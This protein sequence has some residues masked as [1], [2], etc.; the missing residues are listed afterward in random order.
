[1]KKIVLLTIAL[2]V[3]SIVSYAQGTVRGKI[4]DKN[5]ET[6]IGVVVKLA[7]NPAGGRTTDFDGNFSIKL[8]DSTLQTLIITYLGFDT[9][10]ETVKA[11]NNEVIVKDFT[12]KE[13]SHEQKVVEIVAKASKAKEYYMENVKKNSSTTIDFISAETMK[14]TGDANV[15]AAI[16]RVP[17]VSTSVDG[18]ITVRGIGDRY[19]KTTIN[20][21]RIPTLDPFTNNIKL[22]MIPANLVDNV[23]IEKTA[24]PHLPG[25]WAGAYI[26]VVT[27]DYPDKL[28]LNVES[29][30]GY[31]TQSTFKDVLSSHRSSTDWLGYDSDRDHS[32]DKNNAVS[33]ANVH[34]TQYQEYVAL[35]LG[36][37]FK[38][39]GV[40][41]KT[42]WTENY[43][44]LGLVQL[45]LLPKGAFNDAAA[46]ATAKDKYYNGSYEKDAFNTINAN[47]GK[48]GKSF[49][50]NWNSTIRKAPINFSQ[51]FTIGNQ[52]NVFKRPLGFIAGFR[53]GTT[54]V[55]DPNSSF[56]RAGTDANGNQ[57]II[58]AS[59]QR[60][61]RETNGWSAL[62]QAAYKY[63]PN[64]GISLLFMPNLTGI[65]RVTNADGGVN[66]DPNTTKSSVLQFYEQRK[67]F[68][69]QAKSSHYIPWHKIKIDLDAS[70]TNAKSSAPDFKNYDYLQ[71][72]N[73]QGIVG[74]TT[75]NGIH[76]YFR[77]LTDNLFDSKLSV[78]IPVFEKPALPRK[79][80][81]GA[82]YQRNDRKS[83][84]YDYNVAF[85]GN[86]GSTA[87]INGDM[88]SVFSLNRFDIQNLTDDFGRKYSA[89]DYYYQEGGSP[90]N[91]TF[92]YSKIKAAYIMTDFSIIEALRISGGVRVEQA[93][94][95]TDVFKYDSLG[96][97]KNDVR[98]VYDGSVPIAN[99]GNLNS[100]N[101]LPS[102]SLIYKVKKDEAAPMNLRF[103]FSQTLARPSIR[104][105]S[106]I[107]VFDYQYRANV[108]G[109]SEL[110]IV[111]VNNYDFRYEAYF[112]NNDNVSV[113]LFYKDFKNN[114]ELVNEGFYTWENVDKSTVKGIELD[115]KKKIYKGLQI[116]GNATFV[117]SVTTLLPSHTEVTAGKKVHIPYAGAEERS[118]PMFGQ[119]PY[120]FNAIL[121][122]THDSIGLTVAVS[123]NVQGPKL[124]IASSSPKPEEMVPDV[125]E[126]QRH[127]LNLK[128]TKTLGKHFSVS[129][130]LQDIL[131]SPVRRYYKYA[132]GFTLEYDTY[133]WGTTYMLNIAY[134]L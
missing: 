126:L 51:S 76:R 87:I 81:F 33:S 18:F 68:V 93:N 29:S 80:K 84:Q 32:H 37:Y 70:Y 35:G 36:D 15:T 4:A 109:N 96:Y 111:N 57:R 27:K 47:S 73:G 22:D 78:E 26:S 19:V 128:A 116:S 21:L 16:A 85:G 28:T 129:L 125:Y 132:K 25:D 2:V 39:I 65:N 83:D 41:E 72:A 119:S 74:P 50:D 20:G 56:S 3:I 94:V 6:L 107:S 99:P 24:S 79:L 8:N 106:D 31:N 88:N 120:I 90:I 91:H 98:R 130:T 49:A 95:F 14:K 54:T 101:F 58:A 134:K 42:P 5:G 102:V 45:G 11:V 122:Y 13:V 100:T 34:P 75:G 117:N 55:Y 89:I 97:A 60:A 69:Y 114:I 77:Y 71:D 12:M 123:Y 40:N 38:S 63:H 23:I 110:K 103:N 86:A 105:L 64:H 9:I 53:Y 7:S 82:A 92:G 131:N 1:M 115:G 61:S 133:R 43:N 66:D 113:S 44:K 124:A 67:Q 52:F 121:S 59:G 108:I 17:G 30:F 48:Y 10:K 46:V 104:E 62:F 118:R 127:L 112:K